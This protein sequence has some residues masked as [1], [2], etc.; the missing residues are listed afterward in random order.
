MALILLF[1]QFARNIYRDTEEAFSQDKNAIEICIN[2]IKKGFDEELHTVQRIFYYMPLMHSEDISMQEKSIECFSNLAKEFAT[3]ESIAKMVS[4]SFEYAMKHY[5]I[6]KR[7]GRY[8]HRNAILGRE[9]TPEEI[10]FISEPG[11]SF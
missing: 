6:V 9:S 8:P 5:E 7:F 4:G 1:D 10:E 3:S 2:G 11:S